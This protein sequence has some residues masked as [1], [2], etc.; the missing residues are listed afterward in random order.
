[1]VNA[2]CQNQDLSFVFFQNVVDLIRVHLLL[3]F[4][5][6]CLLD[7]TL[8]PMVHLIHMVDVDPESLSKEKMACHL[9][10]DLKIQLIFRLSNLCNDVFRL[11]SKPYPVSPSSHIHEQ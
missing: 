9:F 1:M 5:V 10:V 7:Y 2:N 11:T 4:Q 6:T 8:M 3:T